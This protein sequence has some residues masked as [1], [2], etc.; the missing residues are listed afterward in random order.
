MFEGTKLILT[1]VF[2]LAFLSYSF[3]LGK[4]YDKMHIS[5][6]VMIV[7]CVVLSVAVLVAFII[8]TFF[9][10]H[11]TDPNPDRPHKG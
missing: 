5:R 2:T 4:V 6:S 1:L 9:T 3:L 11:T 7:I 8:D 10:K